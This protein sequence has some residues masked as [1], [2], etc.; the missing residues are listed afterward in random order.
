MYDTKC[1]DLAE[2]FLSDT[3]EHATIKNTNAL[4]QMIQDT[5][6]DFLHDLEN[7]EP[8]DEEETK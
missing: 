7:P 6:E 8:E 5:I 4:A 1:Y 2:E 3:P